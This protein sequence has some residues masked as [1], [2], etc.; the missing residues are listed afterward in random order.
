MSDEPKTG[1]EKRDRLGG[2]ACLGLALVGAV[3]LVTDHLFSG[4]IAYVVP[5]LLL[6]VIAGLWFGRPLMRR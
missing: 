6:A 5:P 1:E 2:L 4:T 3:L